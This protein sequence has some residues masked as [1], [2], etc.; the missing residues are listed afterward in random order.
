VTLSSLLAMA[1]FVTVIDRRVT[2]LRMLLRR[3]VLLEGVAM[4]VAYSAWVMLA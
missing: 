1:L 2:Q 3:L 4:T